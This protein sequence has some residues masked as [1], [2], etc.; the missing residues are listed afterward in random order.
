MKRCALFLYVI[1]G[2]L[3]AVSTAQAA[4]VQN[5][6]IVYR[7]DGQFNAF[8]ANDVDSITFSNISVDSVACSSVV[9]QIFWS[10]GVPF[11]VPV[12][13]T[14]SVAFTAPANRLQPGVT[15]LSGELMAHLLRCEDDYNLIFDTSLPQNLIPRSGDRLVTLDMTD[16]L[17]IGFIGEVNT[18]EST[19]DHILVACDEIGLSD[20]YETFFGSFGGNISNNGKDETTVDSEDE[21][22]PMTA[23]RAISTTYDRTLNLPTFYREYPF[24]SSWDV[25]EALEIGSESKFSFSVS[26]KLRIRSFILVESPFKMSSSTMVVADFTVNEKFA[27]S[28]SG[29]MEKRFPLI[30]N[31]API[32]AAPALKLFVDLGL[33]LKMDGEFGVDASLTQQFRVVGHASVSNGNSDDN[34]SPSLDF[35]WINASVDEV[36]A[37]GKASF[38]V[39][40]YGQIGVAALCKDLANINVDIDAG[41][42]FS[43][44]AETDVRDIVDSYKSTAFYESMS[45][46]DA[47]KVDYY[48]D[49]TLNAEASKGNL[50]KHVNLHNL[51]IPLLQKSILPRFTNVSASRREDKTTVDATAKYSPGLIPATPGFTAIEIKEDTTLSD[52]W[53]SAI[54]A[55]ISGNNLSATLYDV[56]LNKKYDVYTTLKAFGLD[57]LGGKS[58]FNAGEFVPT[59]IIGSASVGD[60]V[61]I[62]GYVTGICDRGFIL[63]DNSGSIY[64]YKYQFDVSSVRIGTQIT[65][66][67]IISSYNRGL[68]INNLNRD[69][70]E[71]D[72]EGFDYYTYPAPS[73]QTPSMLRGIVWGTSLFL[74]KYICF[75]GRI[76]KDGNYWNIDI[77]CEDAIGS[78]YGFDPTK[79]DLQHGKTYTF[80]GYLI[81]A[82][83]SSSQPRYFNV[84]VTDIH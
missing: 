63:T 48:R 30:K 59:N 58:N 45:R 81:G 13:V 34:I 2:L 77:G 56:D 40:T 83:Y 23:N 72:I 3:C 70:C 35:K 39:G 60:N 8:S 7:N 65:L 84:I 20:V 1:V 19:P 50:K 64:C 38:S 75:E 71:W 24:K 82:N 61:E 46:H 62:R 80:E 41:W 68:Q 31:S 44:N 28:F 5:P 33:A 4:D 51:I 42:R 53:D 57:I 17:P 9:T 74:P 67:G 10:G 49:I 18:V 54:D 14:D 78:V 32:A 55:E 11:P 52:N 36:K 15:E 29:S 21:M 27:Q 79:F 47:F 12:E 25:A 69:D 43:I 22:S 6:M 26:P 16:K 73:Y 76:D 66:K 37:A